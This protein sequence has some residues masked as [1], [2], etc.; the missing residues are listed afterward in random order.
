MPLMP[1]RPDRYL[2]TPVL[3]GGEH[4]ATLCVIAWEKGQG[5][6]LV[7]IPVAADGTLG[8]PTAESLQDAITGLTCD[9][10]PLAVLDGSNRD[11]AFRDDGLKVEVSHKRGES[12]VTL[13]DNGGG[14][15]L[16]WRAL[17][18]AAAPTL[19]RADGGI[20]IAFHHNVREDTHEPDLAKWIAVR[21]VTDAGEV[22]E[23]AAQMTD[24]DRDLHGE[25]QSFEFPSLVVGDQGAISIFGRGSHGFFRQDVSHEGFSP[26]TALGDT[27]WGCRGRRVAVLRTPAGI[28]TARREREGIVV[29]LL[30]AP[31]GTTPKLVAAEVEVKS[32]T[33]IVVRARI[34]PT[35]D[36]RVTLFGDIHQHSAHSDGIGTADECYLRARDLLG[37]DFCALTDHESF[38]G[39]RTGPGEWKY[40]RAVADRYNEPGRFATIHAYE[41]TGR[42]FP[43]PGHKVVYLENGDQPIVSRDD[44]P[45]G[46]ALVAEIKAQGGF[47]VPH[48][49]GWTGADELAHDPVVQPVWEICSCHGCYE[50]D[51]HPLGNRKSALTDQTIDVMLRKGLKFGFIACSD[52]HGLLWHHGIARKRDAFGTGLT[53]VQAESCTR[54]AILDAIRARR[55]YA[56]SGTKII[57]DLRANGA[58]MGS[59]VPAGSA[60]VVAQAHGTADIER[61]ELI[62]PDGVLADAQGRG[63]DAALT[64]QI[65][66]RYVYARVIQTD[67]EWAW[68]SPIFF[69][70]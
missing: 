11:S 44:V 18:I 40:L 1:H 57:L 35:P 69:G 10:V 68:S 2:R 52:S 54:K 13:R 12:A 51:E 47:A 26:R 60:D 41:W 64:K 30:P 8:E 55:C 45:E 43:G 63:R 24:R 39:K 70:S 7:Q 58:P 16:V 36:G 20:W 50:T 49:V 9:R 67:G 27:T 65:D 33:R 31:V 22:F 59:E 23:P 15:T 37:H 21:F 28:L 17:G 14:E 38:S 19:A 48:H 6:R 61:I 29:D 56:T 5:E 4:A 42:A 66:T 3:R 34:Q 32:T 46:S 62:G 53:A 25:Q